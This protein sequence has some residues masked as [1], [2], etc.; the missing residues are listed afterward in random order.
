ME[1]HLA[2]IAHFQTMDKRFWS[3]DTELTYNGHTYEAAKGVFIR[4]ATSELGAPAR[5][6]TLSFVVLESADLSVFTEDLGPEP[7]EIERI[8]SVDHGKTWQATGEKFVGR[9]STGELAN[10]LYTL[11]LETYTGDVDRG[12]PR[13]WS[14]ETQAIR[15]PDSIDLGLEMAQQLEGAENKDTG[16]PP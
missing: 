9:A 16:W 5:R 2:W 6:A 12:E 11:E 1:D 13:K 7:V 15:V 14:H 3:G 4:N 8:Y 10:G